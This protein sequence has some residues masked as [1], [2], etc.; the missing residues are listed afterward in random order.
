M[1]L[2]AEQGHAQ[3]Q[4]FLGGMYANGEG[5]PLDFKKSVRWFRLAAEQGEVKA[6]NNLGLMYAMG[7]GA[8]LDFKDAMQWYRLAAMQGTQMPNST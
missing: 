6:Q 8:P 7:R 3:A 2:A 5:A 1:L 4:E